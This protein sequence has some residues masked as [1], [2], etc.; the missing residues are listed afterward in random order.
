MDG[1]IGADRVIDLFITSQRDL[2]QAKQEL[3]QA[4]RRIEELEMQLGCQT[5][6]RLVR[7]IR[8]SFL[9]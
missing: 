1:R 5:K 4:K 7:K 3:E 6:K 9:G 2:H 8:G